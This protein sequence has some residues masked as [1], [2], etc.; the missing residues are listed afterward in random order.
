MSLPCK[1]PKIF[2][3]GKEYNL[4]SFQELLGNMPLSEVSKFTDGIKPIPAM[5]FEK[6]WMEL[7]LKRML[8]YA[9]ENGYD[10]IAWTTG[11]MQADRYDLSK[12]VDKITYFKNNDG[13]YNLVIDAK[14]QD[15]PIRYSNLTESKLSDTV[16]KDVAE[17]IVKNEGAK[18]N[19]KEERW[20]DENVYEFAGELEGEGLKVGGE[21]MKGFYDKMIPSFL[22]KYAKKWGARVGETKI[23][24]MG[25]KV[26]S[27][28]FNEKRLSETVPFLPITESMKESVMEGQVLFESMPEFG[29]ERA[30]REGREPNEWQKLDGNV[31]DIGSAIFN[32][33][34]EISSTQKLIEK[35]RSVAEVLKKDYNQW[36]TNIAWFFDKNPQLQRIWDVT[37]QHLV[38]NINEETAILMED[39][40]QNAKPFRKLSS[41]DKT[42]L[43]KS[44]DSYINYLYQMKQNTGKAQRLT[45]EQF[46]NKYKLTGEVKDFFLEVY[47]PLRTKQLEL[48]EDHDKYM[49]VNTTKDNPFLQDYESA[50]NK[51]LFLEQAKKEFFELAPNAEF[52]FEQEL[53][54]QKRENLGID[55]VKALHDV[56]RNNKDIR[57]IVADDLI[58]QKYKDWRD[59]V[60]F[61][62]S[63]LDHKYYVSAY[64]PISEVD[65]LMYGKKTSGDKVFYTTDSRKD[66]EELID[67]LESQGYKTNLG[68]FKK[69]QDTILENAVTTEDI[70][71]L[72]VASNI[73]IDNEVVTK[74]LNSITA[75]GF[76]RHFIEKNYI[77]GFKFSTENFEKALVRNIHGVVHFKNR[78]IG[79]NELS[80]TMEELKTKGILKEG[81]IETDYINKMRVQLTNQDYD[82]F[83]ALRTAASVWYLTRPAYYGQQGF[84]PFQTLLPYVPVVEKELGL[85]K[86]EGEKAFGEAIVTAHQ[87]YTWKVVDKAHRILGSKLDSNFGLDKEFLDVMKRLERQGVGKPLRSLEL[88]GGQVDP[89]KHYK[90]GLING[91]HIG[92]LGDTEVRFGIATLGKLVGAPGILLEDFTRAIGIRTFYLMGKKAGLKGD[93]LLSMI[94][95]NIAK[96]YGA[97]SGKLS[98][99]PGYQIGTGSGKET[100][101]TKLYRSVTNAYL[102]F[103]NFAFMNYGQWG[104]IWRT[105][106]KDR[107]YRAMMYKLAGTFGVTGL[108][109][110]MWSSTI[111]TFL[112]FLAG[113]FDWEENPEEKVEDVAEQLNRILPGLGTTLYVGLAAAWLKVDLSALF[114]QSAPIITEDLRFYQ[115]GPAEAVGGAPLQVVLD[116]YNILDRRDFMAGAPSGIK[117]IKK[118]EDWEEKGVKWGRKEI[119]SRAYE[120]LTPKERIELKSKAKKL[121]IPLDD[122]IIDATDILMKKLGLT[123]TKVG[124][125][126]NRQRNR[127]FRSEQYSD[128]LRRAIS[129]DIVPLIES[130]NYP[131]ARRKLKE[132][133]KEAQRLNINDRITEL[134]PY[135]LSKFISQII[136]RITDEDDRR[137]L[138]YYRDN[139]LTKK[140]SNITV[141]E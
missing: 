8:R 54:K 1:N 62:T 36:L 67:L 40:W 77:P 102:T 4:D 92:Y 30:R 50:K 121:G 75:K 73:S 53:L 42:T 94:S 110:I 34:G 68:E 51:K 61:P 35:Y 88:V 133:F 9:A 60:E 101:L 58:E 26:L 96:T 5:P 3:K 31:A 87:Y 41:E 81:S 106:R 33:F 140:K 139:I 90:K 117:N 107:L 69:M 91:Y 56:W 2:Y 29:S 21:G 10:G 72:V 83:R 24:G 6:G 100:A 136:S 25:R 22:N 76:R 85:K 131:K 23:P 138:Q 137:V 65:Q 11:E 78:G 13:T 118:A 130:R 99:P 66:A 86:G 98:K 52:Y 124:E 127:D 45:Y 135:E 79:L 125:A 104:K 141:I 38:R 115:G 39:Y 7:S 70:I 132:Y 43:L 103:K 47:K 114:S 59:K 32:N 71:D 37:D 113:L 28:S 120:L 105:L 116:I 82:A 17:R 15:N 128:R 123:T 122:L 129:D 126:Y 119:I 111:M 74:L 18:P 134:K 16:G 95:N 93:E 48:I 55:E 44:F 20:Y 80:T 109:F 89:R 27:N 97:A 63:R 112:S 49:I 64:R 14:Q 12:Q 84:Q 57:E 19:R 108:K 46:V